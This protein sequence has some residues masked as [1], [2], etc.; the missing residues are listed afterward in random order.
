MGEGSAPG[1]AAHKFTKI[2]SFGE[3]QHLT[4]EIADGAVHS[5]FSCSFIDKGAKSD[6]LDYAFY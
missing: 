1:Q 5:E 4:A 6:T 2:V 3:Y